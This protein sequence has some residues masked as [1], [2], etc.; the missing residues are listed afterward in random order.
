MT[1]SVFITKANGTRERF[2]PAKLYG[3]LL[4]AGA[5][6]EAADRVVPEVVSKL[7]SGMTT[8][9]I[10]RQAFKALHALERPATARYSLKR[11]LLDMGPSGFPFEKFVAEI[12]KRRGYETVLDQIVQGECVDHEVDV[13]AWNAGKLLMVEAKFHNVLGLK[14]DLKVALAS[15]ARYDDLLGRTFRYGAERELDEGWLITNT[16]FT[17]KASRYSECAG[18]NV[19]GWNHPAKGNL[20]DLIEET[21]LHP[22]TCLS[23]VGAAERRLLM[24]QGIVLCGQVRDDP[25]ALARVGMSKA[26]AEEVLEESR[27][28]C[29][30]K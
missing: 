19:V 16:N 1:E 25:A 20:H 22:L 23:T 17:E 2:D 29:P 3:S 8:A 15:K 18:I 27:L 30:A 7:S 4:K 21:G 10:Y 11:A 26:K 28:F 6:K 14:S 12:F 13:V 5:S 24:E 9:E